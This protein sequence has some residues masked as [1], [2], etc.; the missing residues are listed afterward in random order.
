MGRKP[1]NSIPRWFAMAMI[2]LL[3]ATGILRLWVEWVH[4]SYLFDWWRWFFV[5]W[6]YLWIAM[7]FVF[8]KRQQRNTSQP[9]KN[10]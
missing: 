9:L 1:D 6:L 4:A 8:K 7:L 3:V 5:A 10:P 2:I